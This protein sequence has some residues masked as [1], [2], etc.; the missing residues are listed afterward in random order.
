[1]RTENIE[2]IRFERAHYD[3]FVSLFRRTFSAPISADSVARKYNTDYTGV[4]HIGFAAF[5][6]DRMIAYYGVIPTLI[7]IGG[8]QT[9]ACQS[10]DTMTDPEYKGRGLFPRLAE[11]TYQIGRAHV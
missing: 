4:S 9:L 1:M 10:A 5:Q 2:I 7:W 8:E 11:M 3:A 6:N